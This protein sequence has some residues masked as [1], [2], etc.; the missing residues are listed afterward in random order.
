MSQWRRVGR[1]VLCLQLSQGGRVISG[2]DW[3]QR[4]PGGY[5]PNQLQRLQ[6]AHHG[7][8]SWHNISLNPYHSFMEKSDFT[9]VR[10]S[11][12]VPTTMTEIVV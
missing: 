5:S 4:Q 1:N 9:H 12:V 3:E 11:L 2:R 7:R 6:K 8:L 10:T